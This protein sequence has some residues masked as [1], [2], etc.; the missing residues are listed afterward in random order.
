[1]QKFLLLL[2]IV[3]VCLFPFT[4]SAQHM[5]PNATAL[6]NVQ[7]TGSDRNG[8]LVSISED[9]NTIVKGSPGYNNGVGCA[10]VY[11]RDTLGV[12]SGGSMLIQGSGSI[13]N[14]NQGSAVAISADGST[15]VVGGSGDNG[16]IGAIW[17]YQRAGN[18]NNFTQVGDKIVPVDYNGK[19]AFGTSVA[20]SGDG[21]RIVGGG[22]K[23]HVT[24]S[25]FETVTMSF[26]R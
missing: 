8:A 17:V 12:W 25:A 16:G 13:G 21:S 4:A 6:T 24:I 14:A 18:S 2:T 1:M 7:R 3:L 23:D 11:F 15:I 26:C 19:P 9:G 5:M 20:V 10:T 22:P